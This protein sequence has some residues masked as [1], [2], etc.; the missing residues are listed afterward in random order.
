MKGK[1]QILDKV[2][3]HTNIACIKINGIQSSALIDS[4]SQISTITEDF[5]NSLENKSMDNF[6]LECK[7]ASGG[8]IPYKD[9]IHANI[10]TEFTSQPVSTVLL[11]VP[12]HGT[13]PILLG[14]NVIREVRMA[15][16]N[17]AGPSDEWE[18][19]FMSIST[20]AGKVTATKDIT[21]HPMEIRT[22]TGFHRKKGNIESAVTEQLESH[23]HSALACPRV[24]AVKTPG[25]NARIPV[26]I[27]NIT[28]RPIKI[29]AKADLCQ[30]QEV[31]VLREAPVLQQVK[32]ANK[33]EPAPETRNKEEFDAKAKYGVDLEDTD[34]SLEQKQKV[35][36]LFEKWNTK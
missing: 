24:I 9:Y 23:S 22:V 32:T 7:N 5:Y 33:S 17:D 20:N 10:E 34:L 28:A 12:L 35:Y 11:V 1:E 6:D 2:V 26:R 21:L 25:K 4:G 19:A 3:G 18:T 8:T 27:C 29:K 15:T 36:D 13:V 30:L 31:K 16:P 14:T